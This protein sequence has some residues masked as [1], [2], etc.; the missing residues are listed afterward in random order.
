MLRPL[1]YLTDPV[2]SFLSFPPMLRERMSR[3]ASIRCPTVAPGVVVGYCTRKMKRF[4][5]RLIAPPTLNRATSITSP[6]PFD[7]KVFLRVFARFMASLIYYFE[8]SSVESRYADRGG[9]F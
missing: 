6:L 5:E 4:S 1:G 8:D 9:L 2:S 7:N 3:S